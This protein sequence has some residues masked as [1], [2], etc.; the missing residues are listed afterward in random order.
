[1]KKLFI[2][3][4]IFFLIDF[5]T[6]AQNPEYKEYHLNAVAEKSQTH[7]E[8]EMPAPSLSVYLPPAEKATGRMIIALPGGGYS[9]LAIAHEG[10]D[11]AKYFLNQGIAYGVLKY[12][13]P[14][15]DPSIP[16]SDVKA[17]FE[18]AKNL[19]KEWHI[20]KN[21]IGI[22]G[23]S[24][25]GHLAAT[26]STQENTE[27]LPA[28]QI[29]LY[30]VITMDAKYTHIGSRNNLIG[31][32]PEEHL[33]NKYSLEKQVKNHNPK[34]FIVLATD[35]KAVV[36]ANALFY[37]NALA[38]NGVPVSLHMYPAGGHGFGFRDTFA[39]KKE[40][41]MELQQWLSSF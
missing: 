37:S 33:V 40:L 7:E 13:M 34:A 36:P 23:S 24:A 9:H 10:Y 38:E 28:F 21:D 20:N 14:E 35:D 18:L 30:P 5:N 22:M 12:R 39:H 2:I 41:L 1:M 4:A 27:E 19:A 6:M 3:L 29:L 8:E 16:F 26:F 31:K 32:T 15:T 17:S 11:F 25:G